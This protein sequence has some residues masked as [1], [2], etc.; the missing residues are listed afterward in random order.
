[1]CQYVFRSLDLFYCFDVFVCV[2]VCVNMYAFECVDVLG[3]A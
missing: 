2:W 1:M 3:V